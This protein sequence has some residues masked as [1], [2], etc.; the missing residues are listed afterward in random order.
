VVGGLQSLQVVYLRMNGLFATLSSEHPILRTPH[1]PHPAPV[2]LSLSERPSDRA[3]EM[4][5]KSRVLP[6]FL[7]MSQRGVEHAARPE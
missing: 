1:L 2:N 3:K 5:L 7:S 6:D 4:R